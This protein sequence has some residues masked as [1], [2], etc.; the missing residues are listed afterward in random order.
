MSS[1]GVLADRPRALPDQHVDQV[2]KSGPYR[3]APRH[4]DDQTDVQSPARRSLRIHDVCYLVMFAVVQL[5][6][7]ASLGYGLVRL[8]R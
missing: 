6:W 3:E 2:R 5:T 1:T 7:V 8:I 4:A